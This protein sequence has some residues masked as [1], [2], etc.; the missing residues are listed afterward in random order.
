MQ[1]TLVEHRQYIDREGRDMP[2]VRD[3][4]WKAVK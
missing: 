3:W 1:D 4:K 2:E